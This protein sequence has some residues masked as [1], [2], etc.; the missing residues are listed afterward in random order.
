MKY[1]IRAATFLLYASYGSV[2]GQNEI[3]RNTF[4]ELNGN[5]SGYA[6]RYRSVKESDNYAVIYS[7]IPSNDSRDIIQKMVG[8]AVTVK[9]DGEIASVIPLSHDIKLPSD[10]EIFNMV[11]Q[12][13]S[14]NQF[15]SVLN[16]TK[17]S[18]LEKKLLIR[19]W[20]KITTMLGISIE[21]TEFFDP[22][23]IRFIGESF[24]RDTTLMSR[25]AK[26]SVSE[27]RKSIVEFIFS[28]W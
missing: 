4:K 16:K 12:N 20:Y 8:V 19:E 11:K 15:R 5:F 21:E 10:K 25:A 14:F 27:K 3:Q 24:G 13:T 6:I 9:A 26:L 7:V 2:F 28:D 1:S 18:N 22:T 17:Y 23:N